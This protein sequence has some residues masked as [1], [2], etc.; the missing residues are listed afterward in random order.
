M[1]TVERSYDGHE[2]ICRGEWSEWSVKPA[3]T[4]WVVELSSSIQGNYTCGKYLV[5]YAAHWPQGAQLDSK[6]NETYVLADA[7]VAHTPDGQNTRTLR[8]PYRVQ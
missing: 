4:G 1:E 7:I 8:R 5:Q 2:Y 6:R 3:K